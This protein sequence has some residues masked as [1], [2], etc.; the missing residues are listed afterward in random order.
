MLSTGPF[1]PPKSMGDHADEDVDQSA[2]FPPLPVGAVKDPPA[3]TSEWA[4]SQ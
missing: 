3:H 2:A 4:L 1:R